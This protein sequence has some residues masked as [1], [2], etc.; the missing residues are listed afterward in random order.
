[1]YLNNRLEQDF[2]GIKDRY[3]SMRGFRA[4]PQ[5]GDFVVPS[6][7]FGV[8]CAFDP[9]TADMCPPIGGDCVSSVALSP[10]WAFWKPRD[11]NSC[12]AHAA[13]AIWREC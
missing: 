5:L 13:Q 8:F 1:M 11:T 12:L 7:S 10:A 9:S 2:R 4:W 3:R 6:T